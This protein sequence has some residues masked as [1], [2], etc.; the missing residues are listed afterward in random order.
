MFLTR[1]NATE[2]LCIGKQ[3]PRPTPGDAKILLS[4]RKIFLPRPSSRRSSIKVFFL[5]TQQNGLYKF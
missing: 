5:R 3:L 1:R 2:A 4:N